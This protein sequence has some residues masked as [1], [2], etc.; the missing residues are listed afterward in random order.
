MIAII[1]AGGKGTRLAEVAKGIPKPMVRVGNKSILT[2]QIE[3]LRNSGVKKI[4]LII[5]YLGEVIQEYYKNGK[6]FGVEIEY[7]KEQEPL[8]TAG[9]L[10]YLKEKLQESAYLIFG[11]IFF[12]INLNKF[13]LFH[14][15]NNS[16]LTL[17][18]HPNSHPYDSDLIVLN[19]EK[20]LINWDSKHNLRNYDYKN[21]V[22]AGIYIINPK[23][24]DLFKTPTKTDLEKD[25]IIPLIKNENYKIFG[26]ETSEYVKDAGTVDRYI[27]AN[28]DEEN[29]LPEYKNISRKQH[30]IFLDRDGTINKYKGLINS[31]EEIEL[32]DKVVDAIK[33]INKS[34]Y[35]AVVITN[36]PVVARGECDIAGLERINNRIETLLGKEG[37]YLDA[38][39]YCP[40]HPDKGFEGERV[41]YKIECNCRKPKI[42]LIKKAV[43]KFNI[44]LEKSYFIGDTTMDFMTAKNAGVKSVLVKTGEKGL[45]N[46]FNIKADYEFDNLYDAVKNIIKVD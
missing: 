41:E 12:D 2:H 15:A 17:L 23:I 43:E 29:L 45:D 14:M 8:G 44:D 32:E 37:C 31:P 36:Q 11:D 30:C 25:V 20:R 10:Y 46:K 42:G 33:L 3:L 38:L 26:Y 28:H 4:Y 13:Q 24:L 34:K 27:L 39:F 1:M 22:N 40:H 16:D 21:C 9:G 6:D 7:I 5:G 35:L 19:N 18:V